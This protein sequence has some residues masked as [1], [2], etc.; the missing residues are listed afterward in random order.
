M[1]QQFG[2]G[3]R[4]KRGRA[5]SEEERRVNQRTAFLE[6]A[7]REDARRQKSASNHNAAWGS[8]RTAFLH[9][10]EPEEFHH[11]LDKLDTQQ[12]IG[13]AG[14]SSSGCSAGTQA[15]GAKSY[16]A[17]RMAT[18]RNWRSERELYV[19]TLEMHVMVAQA[20][21]SNTLKVK[22]QLL[23]HAVDA[24]TARPYHKC[25]DD[26]ISTGLAVLLPDRRSVL[27]R[28]ARACFRVS[29][30]RF[31]CACC[32]KRFAMPATA[33]GCFGNTPVQPS[34]WFDILDLQQ[35]HNLA[36]S[37]TSVSAFTEALNAER[38]DMASLFIPDAA[39]WPPIDERAFEEAYLYYRGLLHDFADPS[40]VLG[41]ASGYYPP[42]FGRCPV[43]GISHDEACTLLQSP[44]QCDEIHAKVESMLGQRDVRLRQWAAGTTL[45][46][47]ADEEQAAPNQQ[48]A[49]QPL[50]LAEEP[51]ASS[52]AAASALPDPS[53]P[54]V[55]PAGAQAGSQHLCTSVL[56][57]AVSFPTDGRSRGLLAVA[58]AVMKLSHYTKCGQTHTQVC[59][60]LGVKPL[61]ETY[62]ST[63]NL[64]DLQRRQEQTA[65]VRSAAAGAVPQA[66]GFDHVCQA[67]LSC[68]R[69]AALKGGAI[70]DIKCT[71][72]MVCTHV[73]PGQ[74]LFI[75][76]PSPEHYMLYDV[77]LLKLGEA[78]SAQGRSLQGFLLDI[79]CRYKS[80]FRIHH[81][82][83]Y[84]KLGDGFLWMIG[85]LHSRAGHNL[86][87][88]MNFSALYKPDTG[89]CI[90]EQCEQ[91][92]VC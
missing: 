48:Q 84:S 33:A 28:S 87:C 80:H 44:G 62:V 16:H 35:Y 17:D 5:A 86:Q 83:E 24:F 34:W 50:P 21:M 64:A 82:E 75:H 66:D 77:L 68:A 91:L 76:S 10:G 79:N 3:W 42:V 30:P 72:G 15:P 59:A 19:H 4:V 88:Q 22:Q 46:S 63:D 73:V 41:P 40:R 31:S 69:A 70:T 65:G 74:G 49:E 92:W 18:E 27:Y 61:I 26:K 89:R 32:N 13:T 39:S 52:V 81:S 90:G 37:G 43:C 11:V 45:Q 58:D 9:W 23:K 12:H 20:E 25:V 53:I 38:H 8:A 71:A 47:M 36:M 67:D 56:G 1:S 2:D 78:L 85:W 54:H 29:V 51:A 7:V 57:R 55:E 14:R 60:E 6:A